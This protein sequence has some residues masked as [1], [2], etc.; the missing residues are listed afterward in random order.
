MFRWKTAFRKTPYVM[1]EVAID[2]KG[3]ENDKCAS[4]PFLHYDPKG[5]SFV[6][7]NVRIIPP[8][9][10]LV[11]PPS[12]TTRARAHAQKLPSLQ[13][14]PLWSFSRQIQHHATNSIAA[15]ALHK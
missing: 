11:L 6:K 8:P 15:A 14:I 9:V 10:L 2:N 1:S 4:L 3:G 5:A 7:H 13:C 12:L